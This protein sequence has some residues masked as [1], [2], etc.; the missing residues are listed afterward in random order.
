MAYLVPP[1]NDWTD[2]WPPYLIRIKAIFEGNAVTDPK[3]K[4][5]LLVSALSTRTIEVLQAT[6]APESVNKLPYEEVVKALGDFFSPTPNEIAESFKFFNRH[7]KEDKTVQAFL[8]EL[9][10]QAEKCNF[11]S[12]VDRMLRDRLVCGVR[13]EEVRKRLLARREVTLKEAE[14]I[15]LAAEAAADNVAAMKLPRSVESEINAVTPGTGQGK[16]PNTQKTYNKAR[17][18][19]RD[20][21]SP[22]GCQRCGARSHAADSCKHRSAQCFRRGSYGHLARRCTRENASREKGGRE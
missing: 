13:S 19:R 22:D 20:S 9:R 7:Q 10:R 12:M 4:R 14:N 21:S 6:C 17:Y 15:A 11:G 16:R 3:T 1:F 2:K 18:K 8:V 5:A